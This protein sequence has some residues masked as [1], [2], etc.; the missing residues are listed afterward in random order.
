MAE[1]LSFHV[2]HQTYPKVS[3]NTP[4]WSGDVD[5]GSYGLGDCMAALVCPLLTEWKSFI[6]KTE[7]QQVF[8][9]DSA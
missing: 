7:L 2:F 1:V 6:C 5:L 8:S 3:K 4:A 9:S